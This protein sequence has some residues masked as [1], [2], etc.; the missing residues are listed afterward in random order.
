MKDDFAMNKLSFTVVL[1]SIFISC[2]KETDVYPT[3]IV[4]IWSN[5][6]EIENHQNL[7]SELLYDFKSDN[8]F[9]IERAIL[10]D[11]SN[12]ILGY[13][14]KATGKYSLNGDVLTINRLQIF[15]H[16]DS[17]GLY[18]DISNLE[19]SDEI[20]ESIV[21]I[22]FNDAYDQLHFH[23]PPCGSLQNCLVH[24]VFERKN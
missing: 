10:N 21:N 18:S 11:T 7:T 20:S 13:R 15:E 19:L 6:I 2:T 22:K 24:E 4:G 16:N 12:E 1:I 5:S 23:Y 8:N 3:E 9:T 14:Y 17:N